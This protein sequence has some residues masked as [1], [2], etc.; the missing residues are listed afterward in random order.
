MQ[1]V[2]HEL[3]IVLKMLHSQA[4]RDFLSRPLDSSEANRTVFLH[5][6][7]VVDNAACSWLSL[8]NGINLNVFQGFETEDDLV[9]YFLHD[10]YTDK[11]TILASEYHCFKNR[12][13]KD[14]EYI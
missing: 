6:L 11:V 5:Q 7:D 9:N 4:V 14:E 2:L 12:R 10:A 1:R 8:V 13:I 3:P